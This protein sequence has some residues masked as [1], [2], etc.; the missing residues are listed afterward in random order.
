MNM[1]FYQFLSIMAL[2]FLISC[3]QNEQESSISPK[4]S[5]VQ[6]QTQ[7]NTTIYHELP[8]DS[9][10]IQEQQRVDEFHAI[11]PTQLLTTLPSPSMNQP[12]DVQEAIVQL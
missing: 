9:Q 12:L 8:N 4:N 3:H 10:T 11:P 5:M 2:G 6:P 7:L 1:S